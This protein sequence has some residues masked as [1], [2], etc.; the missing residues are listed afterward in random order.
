[1][2]VGMRRIIPELGLPKY[3]RKTDL[4]IRIYEA[5]KKDQHV[6]FQ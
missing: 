6:L 4:A 1:M 5:G 3:G 2:Y